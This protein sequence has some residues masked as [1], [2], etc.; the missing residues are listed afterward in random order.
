MNISPPLL[1]AQVQKLFN[2]IAKVA[3]RCLHEASKYGE[4]SCCLV[5]SD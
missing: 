5:C 1:V 4:V 2:E 3:E